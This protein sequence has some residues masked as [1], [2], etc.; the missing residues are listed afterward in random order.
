MADLKL[1][2][3]VDFFT[4]D[5]FVPS[6]LGSQLEGMRLG[7]L[8]EDGN[9]RAVPLVEDLSLTNH[10]TIQVQKNQ[11]SDPIGTIS[12]LLAKAKV[13]RCIDGIL[14]EGPPSSSRWSQLYPALNKLRDR[15]R[16]QGVQLPMGAAIIRVFKEYQRFGVREPHR[17]LAHVYRWMHSLSPLGYPM[18][19]NTYDGLVESFKNGSKL[20][21]RDAC[22]VWADAC[23]ALDKWVDVWNAREAG[24]K[25]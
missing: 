23:M 21:T 25:W 16:S 18:P 2:E 7:Q 8:A 4:S 6:A 3:V 20:S 24:I 10:R 11:D 12:Q 22:E 17:G 15:G 9:K 14:K 13:L 5:T 1:A 19:D